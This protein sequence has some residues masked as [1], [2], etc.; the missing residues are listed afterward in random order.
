VL[1][2]LPRDAEVSFEI[3]L[4]AG[5]NEY[6]IRAECPMNYGTQSGLHADRFTLIAEYESRG[7]RKARRFLIDTSCVA[8]NSARFGAPR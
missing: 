8:H 7:K 3:S 6:L 4:D 2:L 1:E 5:T